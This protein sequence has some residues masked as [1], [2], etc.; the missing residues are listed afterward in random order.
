MA[1]V[2]MQL[3]TAEE[4]YEWGCRPENQDRFCELESGR[5]VDL[6][7]PGKLHG[8]V[9]AN[10]TGILGNFTA[11]RKTG[12]ICS[13]GTGVIVKRNPDTV[14]GPDVLF[15]EDAENLEQVD[16]QYGETPPLLAV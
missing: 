15:F 8:M 16:E 11:Q 6:P 3:M 12:Y 9:C 4:F 2:A 13:N 7:R 1:T 5:I 10:L 14:R